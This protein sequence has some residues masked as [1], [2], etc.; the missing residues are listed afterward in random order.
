M[1]EVR[2]K[3]LVQDVDRHGNLRFYVRMPGR[4]KVRLREQPGTA[5][6]LAEYQKAVNGEH[7]SGRPAPTPLAPQSLRWLSHSYQHSAEFRQL[8]PRTQKVRALILHTIC[9]TKHRT[10]KKLGDMPFAPIQ[11]KH[12]R[13]IRD[14]KA[15][16]TEAA[17]SWLKAL[18]QL[19]RWAVD[20]Q[21]ME[22]NPAA[23]VPYLRSKS[24]GHHAWTVPEVERYWA[25][26]PVG[27]RARL[28][29][30]L[31][32][33]TGQRRG[34]VVEFGPQHVHNGELTLRQEKTRKPLT[35]PMLPILQASIDATPTGP[36]SF[37][38][39]EFGKPFTSN[40]FGNRFR[41]WCDEAGLPHCTAHG[42]RKA[43]AAIAAENGA[44]D[45]QLMA[46][47][48]WDT[49]KE[50]TRY[51]KSADQ[52]RLAREAMP[53]LMPRKSEKSTVPLSADI[54]PSGTIIAKNEGKADV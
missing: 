15:G 22:A 46:I 36:T 31:L 26:H 19:F 51:T 43:G 12:V 48:G 53:L 52:R 5:K 28:A 41:K 8:E 4:P 14:V 30:D 18:R 45:R 13:E 2:L 20:T 27:T 32:L 40:G 49:A 25:A 3:H 6:F 11:P 50:A 34:D 39:T 17:N 1:I 9:S 24:A 54:E 37:L 10:G 33:F 29:I 42:L 21:I 23:Q 44:T 35:L 47:F 7:A 38:V 16:K